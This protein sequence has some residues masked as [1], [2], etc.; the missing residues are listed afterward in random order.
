MSDAEPRIRRTRL[1]RRLVTRAD[2]P[3]EPARAAK[4]LSAYVYGNILVLAAVAASTPSSIENGTAAVLVLATAVTTFL[5][6]VF[7]DFVASSQ[8][9]EAHG[10]ATDEQRTFEAVEEFRDAVPI[11]SSGTVPAVML[12]LGWLSVLPGQWSEL[13]AGGVI[14]IRIATI[15]MVT[16]RIRGNP[17][18]FRAILGGLATAAIAALIVL[19]KVFL[20]H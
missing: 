9:P 5:A 16:E 7:A 1:Y 13:L 14:V 17:L 4:R 8:I 3:L 20:G 19:A 18:T 15:Q 11:L 12:A 2:G 6:H 10:D